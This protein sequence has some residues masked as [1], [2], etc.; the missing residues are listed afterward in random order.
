MRS[1]EECFARA[2]EAFLRAEVLTN[3]STLPP[4]PPHEGSEAPVVVHYP[5]DTYPPRV[6]F[7]WSD[8]PDVYDFVLRRGRHWNRTWQEGADTVEWLWFADANRTDYFSFGTWGVAPGLPPYGRLMDTWFLNML[9]SLECDWFVGTWDSNQDR[10]EGCGRWIAAACLLHTP[11]CPQASRGAGRRARPQA[12]YRL[13]RPGLTALHGD[14]AQRPHRQQSRF[15]PR[16]NSFE[17]RSTESL[18]EV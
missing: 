11:F 14:L 6:G 16:L 5:N 10:R 2:A 17:V 1:N 7:I 3:V 8:D 15:P 12:L 9:T 4:P 18:V 13:T